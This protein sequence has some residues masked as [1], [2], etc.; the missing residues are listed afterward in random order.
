METGKGEAKAE[1]PRS[2]EY[3]DRLITSVEDMTF[4]IKGL[5]AALHDAQDDKVKSIDDLRTLTKAA[6]GQIAEPYTDD[7]KKYLFCYVEQL[8]RI[9]ARVT[10]TKHKGDNY[11]A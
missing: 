4:E 11:D 5:I 2:T 3:E 1:P 6:K 10:G 8:E 7:V 9:I